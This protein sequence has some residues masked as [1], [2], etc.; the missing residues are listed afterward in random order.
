MKIVGE[1]VGSVKLAIGEILIKKR[2]EKG[3][4]QDVIANFIGVSKASISKWETGKTYPDITHLPKIASFYNMTVD[5]LIGYTPQLTKEEIKKQYHE[6]ATQ[7]SKQDFDVVYG[8]SQRIIQKYYACFPLL[9]QMSVLY[10]NHYMLAPTEEKQQEML[11]EAVQL[12]TRIKQES[13]DIWINK[14]ANSL[15]AICYLF[16]KQP[17]K[18]LTLLEDTIK[19]AVG[20]EV[21][22]SNAYQ[23]TGDLEQAMFT[24][25]IS[26]Y[27]SLLN[28][29]GTASSYLLLNSNDGEKFEEII[30][31]VEGI[32]SLYRL[33]ELHPNLILQFYVAVAQGYA[34]QENR[35]KT[36][37]WLE[38]YVGICTTNIFPLQLHGDDYFTLI[39]SWLE[40]LDLGIHAPRDDKTIKESMVKV[41]LEQPAFAF[42][43]E[44]PLFKLLVENLQFAL[45]GKNKWK[46]I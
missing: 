19:P 20:D 40:D 10:L 7:F 14:Q 8:Q 37:Y 25:Q 42:I 1:E 15:Q 6:L 17:E 39:D 36:L 13:D 26:M 5:D 32:S 44:E 46:K 41:M 33:K 45:G 16:L 27:Q 4:T 43:Q 12:C 28:L 30:R 2:E 18:T 21:I 11:M 23:L 3:I 9:L 31:R 24:L 38:Q 29:V 35:E 22:L 34:M